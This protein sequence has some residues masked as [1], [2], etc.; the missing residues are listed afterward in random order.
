MNDSD[1]VTLFCIAF[2]GMVGEW[3]DHFT[4]A[5]SEL[6]DEKVN[7]ALLDTDIRFTYTL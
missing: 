3:K 1:E 5:Q 7:E 4:V 2:A 6:M